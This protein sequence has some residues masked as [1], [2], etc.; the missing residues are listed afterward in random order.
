MPDTD[1]VGTLGQRNYRQRSHQTTVRRSCP[2]EGGRDRRETSQSVRKDWSDGRCD[3]GVDAVDWCVNLTL[4]QTHLMAQTRWGLRQRHNRRSS[5]SCWSQNSGVWPGSGG[6]RPAPA[7]T[8]GNPFAKAGAAKASW[9]MVLPSKQQVSSNQAV[10]L[11]NNEN[12]YS[13][14]GN[15]YSSKWNYSQLW[16]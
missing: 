9:Q 16:N 15:F 5:S 11:W 3:P 10:S 6:P 1:A 7:I 4:L 2:R 12:F 14:K 8:Q 13:A